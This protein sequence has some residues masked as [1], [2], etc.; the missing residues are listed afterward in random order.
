MLT[1]ECIKIFI[2]QANF[3]IVAKNVKEQESN[4]S[5]DFHT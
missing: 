2:K 5:W 4:G 1:Q 3:W